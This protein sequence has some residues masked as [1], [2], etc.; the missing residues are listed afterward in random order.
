L[1][2]IYA[3]SACAKIIKALVSYYIWKLS[4]YSWD[5]VPKMDL[6]GD[7]VG[8]QYFTQLKNVI[9]ADLKHYG[10]ANKVMRD[11]IEEV[12]VKCGLMNVIHNEDNLSSNTENIKAASEESSLVI[13]TAWES[14]ARRALDTL[15]NSIGEHTGFVS[16]DEVNSTIERML[17]TQAGAEK[18][19]NLVGGD[20]KDILE[21]VLRKYN[22]AVAQPLVEAYKR[23][24]VDFG[25]T[26][27]VDGAIQYI[28]DNYVERSGMD[29]NGVKVTRNDKNEFVQYV[30]ENFVPD[31][32]LA[33]RQR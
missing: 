26:P 31:I 18:L 20:Y 7:K 22:W 30:E 25:D 16:L 28:K 5:L 19:K 32:Q 3:G 12:A 9:V 33:L 4:G 14:N 11:K 6:R 29:E 15:V 24:A 1:K 17:S 8:G 10:R 23:S 27:T 13:N 2:N 21:T